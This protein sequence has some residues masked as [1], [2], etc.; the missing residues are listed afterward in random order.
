MTWAHRPHGVRTRGKNN[1]DWQAMSYW[2][3]G[4]PTFLN[5]L[6]IHRQ[7]LKDQKQ[8]SSSCPHW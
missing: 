5:K 3:T 1:E 7:D 2:L 8:I 6:E 4:D